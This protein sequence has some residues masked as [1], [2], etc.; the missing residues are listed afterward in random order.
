MR[1]VILE[2]FGD[3][4]VMKIGEI[5]AP[6]LGEHDIRIA[7]KAA[8]VNRADVLQRQG[9]YPPPPGASEI[10]GMECAG[11]V[12]EVGKEVFGW[13]KGDRAMALLPG[14]GYAAEAVVDAGSAMHV[15]D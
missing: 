12:T 11:V 13:Q 14:G 3:E 5:P 10:L 15:P 1:A 9:H 8:G 7:V 2:K 6:R 4:S